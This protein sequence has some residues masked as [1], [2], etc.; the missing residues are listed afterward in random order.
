MAMALPRSKAARAFFYVPVNTRAALE[1][2]KVL[3]PHWSALIR[4]MNGGDAA[5]LYTRGGD[6]KN[7]A[8]RARY[9]CANGAAFPEDPGHGLSHGFAGGTVADCGEA[10]RRYAQLALGAGL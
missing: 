4:P 9:V 3:E 7:T 8:F 10:S 1:Q 6:G 5:Y 2:S